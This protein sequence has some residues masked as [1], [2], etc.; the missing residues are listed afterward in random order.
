MFLGHYFVS[1]IT[2][3]NWKIQ[4]GKLTLGYFRRITYGASLGSALWGKLRQIY[5]ECNSVNTDGSMESI[6]QSLW[7]V[8][9]CFKNLHVS[10]NLSC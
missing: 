7:N 5:S 9:M 2:S 10:N 3:L 4:W 6:R 8:S 1:P